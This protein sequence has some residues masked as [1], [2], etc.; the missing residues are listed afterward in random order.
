MMQ[1]PVEWVPTII[2]FITMIGT[3]ILFVITKYAAASERQNIAEQVKLYRKTQREGRLINTISEDIKTLREI[4]Y[5]IE[6][7]QNPRSAEERVEFRIRIEQLSSALTRLSWRSGPFTDEVA[8]IARL[9]D[10]S[11]IGIPNRKGVDVVEAADKLSS[12]LISW[13]KGI[14]SEE[15]S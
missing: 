15:I 2:S 10:M 6:G 1:N 5:V 14:L 3:L 11:A 9:A 8:R 4:A 13:L 7:Y 12:D